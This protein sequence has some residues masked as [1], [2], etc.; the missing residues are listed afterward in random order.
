[1][2]T[3]PQPDDAAQPE[4]APEPGPGPLSE[5]EAEELVR[6]AQ[7]C[8]EMA[9]QGDTEG[10]ATYVDAGV[11]VDL[12]DADGSTLI[13]IAAEFGHAATVAALAER[14]ADVSRLD[15]HGRALLAW[16]GQG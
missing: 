11:P 15:E 12:T 3:P 4:D 5:D 1:M 8:L 13:M 2:T 16:G 7:L 9:R 10:L 14:G 6:L